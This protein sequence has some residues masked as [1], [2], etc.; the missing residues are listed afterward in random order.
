ME[1][2]AEVGDHTYGEPNI[3][4]DG[5]IAKLKIGKFCSI[6]RDVYIILSAD[7]N[8]D[9]I[10][11]YPFSSKEYKNDWDADGIGGH[12]TTNGDVIIGNDVWIGF[13]ATIMSGVH[14][15]DGAVIA[16]RAVVTKD[17]S[18]YMIVGGVPAKYIKKRFKDDEIKELLR[19]KW[20]DW[21]T[22]KIKKNVKILCSGDVEE[23]KK[24][25]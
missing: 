15:G 6:A 18:P 24:I 8:I 3:F 12:P 5:H 13:N 11:T 20:W 23:L 25:C 17:V 21:P 1:G 4:H 10:T 16:A 9:W 7:H 19:I 22:D 2:I 14:I